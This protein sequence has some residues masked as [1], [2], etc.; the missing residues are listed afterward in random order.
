MEV[1]IKWVISKELIGL[2]CFLMKFSGFSLNQGMPYTQ[3]TNDCLRGRK[4]VGCAFQ[5]RCGQ[6]LLD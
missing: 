1:F 4:W 2:C 3:F 5:P 6:I